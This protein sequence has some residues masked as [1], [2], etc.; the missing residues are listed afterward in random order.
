MSRLSLALTLALP[1]IAL[2]IVRDLSEDNF[3]RLVFERKSQAP[4]FVKFYAPWCGHCKKLAPDWKQVEK[5][6]ESADLLVGSVDCSDG[7]PAQGAPPGQGGRNPLCDKYKAMGLPTLLYFHPPSKKAQHYDGNKTVDELLGFAAELTSGCSVAEQEACTE[8]Q[9]AHLAT[10]ATMAK[11]ELKEK[12]SSIEMKA[13]T[14]RMRL[15]MQQMQAQQIYGDK[16]LSK[17]AKDEKMAG[18]E[19][20]MKEM[21]AEID[22][23]WAQS[24]ELRVMQMVLRERKRQDKEKGGG[25]GNDAWG[26]VHELDDDD[27]DPMDY[28]GGGGMGGPGGRMPPM[29]PPK[30]KPPSKTPRQQREAKGEAVSGPCEDGG[31]WACAEE[32]CPAPTIGCADLKD[33]CTTKFSEVFATPPEGLGEAQVWK[34]CPKSCDRC[35]TSKKGKGRKGKGRKE[36]L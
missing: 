11:A 26:K 3:Q 21:G 18:F 8:E 20:E 27:F 2:A 32:G 13:E 23:A 19:G 25:K 31:P 10:Y 16:S 36:E 33:D 15:M 1:A 28:M 5:A 12:V 17:E 35:S 9:R 6:Y 24:P 22:A 7:P 29:P 34:H 30:P 14:A 4:A